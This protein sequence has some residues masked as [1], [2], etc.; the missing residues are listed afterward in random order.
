M[1]L[2]ALKAADGAL[3]GPFAVIVAKADRFECDD[4]AYPKSVVGSATIEDWIPPPPPPAPVPEA[5]TRLQLILG[6]TAADLI[7]PA[8]GVAAASGTAIPAVVEA[9]FASLPNDQAT[10]ARIRWAAMTTVERAS[11]LV[12]AVAAGA[13]PPKTDAEM[14]QYFRDWGAL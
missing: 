14:D 12:A 11:P 9:V 2:K 7:S 5:I 1:T 10:A 6:M 8:E 3:F 13:T 4:V